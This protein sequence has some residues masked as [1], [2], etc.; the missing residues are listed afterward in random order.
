MI[1]KICKQ[2]GKEFKVFSYRKNTAM[3]CSYSCAAKSRIGKDAGNWQ[4]GKIKKE[5]KEC[6]EKFEVIPA[7]KNRKFC[8]RDCYDK[9]HSENMIGENAPNWQGGKIEIIECQECN[10]K[11][12]VK[13]YNN[14]RKYCSHKCYW[15]AMEGERRHNS[16]IKKECYECGE[17]FE[18][19]ESQ[20]RKYCSYEC[21]W[22]A[23]KG[24]NA[25][26]W[27]GG[28]SFEPYGVEFNEDLKEVIRNRDR[29]KCQICD[30]TE[31]EKGE[32][33]SVHHIDYDKKNNELGNLIS[34]CRECHGKTSFN[35]EYWKQYFYKVC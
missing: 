34:L 18:A 1:I 31:L 22:K 16:K 20:D 33:L 28:I 3:F 30:K 23:T 27:E 32:K 5:C 19:Y 13:L 2:C 8:S 9:W 15:K 26:T 10:K 6:G 4:G 35:R 11:F 29:R 14:D 17:E 7:R 25:P 24:K 21:Y 12:E